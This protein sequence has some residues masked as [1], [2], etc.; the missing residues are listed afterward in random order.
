[1]ALTAAQALQIVQK[2]NAKATQLGIAVTT[3]VVDKSGFIVACLRM[4]GA[5][6]LSPEIARAKAYTS[7]AFS[8]DTESVGQWAQAMPAFFSAASNLGP[9]PLMPAGGGV[10]VVIGGQM[11][12]GVGVSGGSAEQDAECAKAGLE[13]L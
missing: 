11:V 12:G 6:W 10:P 2:S 5:G 4:D 1:M 7:A 8:V 13:G 3:T 9:T